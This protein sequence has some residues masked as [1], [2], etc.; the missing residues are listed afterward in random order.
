MSITIRQENLYGAEDWKLVYTSFKNAEFQSY[1]FDTLRQAMIAY[2]QLNYPEEYNDYIQSSEFVALVD[3]VAFV[4]QNLSFRMDLNARENIL[5]T[6]EKRESVLR[7]ARM[8]SY[9]P[10][11]VR[12]AEGFLQVVSLKTTDQLIDSIGNNISNQNLTWGSDPSDLEYER[13][14]LAM[15]AALAS[16][17]QFGSPSQKTVNGIT[18]ESY[19]IYQ[20]DNINVSDSYPVSATTDGLNLNFDILPVILTTAGQLNQSIPNGSTPFSLLYRNDGKGIGSIRTGFFALVKQGTLQNQL[21]RFDEPRANA[22]ID[23]TNS[24]NISEDDFVVQTLDNNGN[25]IKTW[26]RVQSHDYENITVNEFG[27]ANKDLYEVIYSDVDVTSIKFGDGIFANA[28]SGIIRVWYRLAENNFIKVKSNEISNK[29]VNINYVNGKGEA[30]TLTLTLSLQE[31]LTTGIPAETTD[32]IKVNAPEAFYSKN[33]MVTGDDYSGLLPSLNNDVL[34]LKTENRTFSGHSR[35]V[36]LQDPSGKSRPLVEIG[37]DGYFY[38]DELIENTYVADIAGVRTNKFLEDYIQRRL[39]DINFLNFYYGKSDIDNTGSG[40]LFSLLDTASENIEWSLAYADK[41]SSNGF[42]TLTSGTGAPLRVGLTT[43]GS[44]RSFRP[45]SLVKFSNGTTSYWTS[46]ADI[47]G[48]GLGS[49]LA[50]GNYSG[51]LKSGHGVVELNYPVA[52]GD[53]L[54]AILPPMPSAFDEATTLALTEFIDNKTPFALILNHTV[55]SWSIIDTTIYDINT[56]DLWT[57]SDPERQWIINVERTT[58]GWNINNRAINYVF[59]S[60]DLI[61][62]YNINFSAT[63]SI[64]QRNA[65]KDDIAIIASEGNKLATQATYRITGYYN[66]SDGYTDNS[67]VKVTPLDLDNDILPDTPDHFVNL[68][69]TEKIGLAEYVEGDFTYYVPV[70]ST[71]PS[72][73]K[74][75]PGVKDLM[76]KWLHKTPVTQTLNPSLTN[77]IDV[78]VLTKTYYDEFV[79][80]KNKGAKGSQ[81]LT[82]T[83]EQL[84]R[85]FKGLL[86]YKMSTDEVVF[87]PVKFKPLFGTSADSELQAQFKVVK[88]LKSSKTENEIKSK[89]LAAIDKFFTPGNFDFGE[90]FY[91]TELAAYIHSALAEDINSVV[92]VPVSSSGSF[93]SLFQI[94]PN[95]D[96]LVTSVATV[97]DIVVIKEITNQN[98]RKI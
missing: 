43:A 25:V 17:N 18:G 6:A 10:K 75:V 96:E 67:K 11:R 78:Y 65:S 30:H 60:E 87:H 38:Q 21:F 88:N 72:A 68:V 5:D 70:D 37:D 52:A 7:I 13:F 59:G 15:N 61:R 84:R 42:L 29:T 19:G 12:P 44:L 26:S 4:G 69:G 98:I 39:L 45:G 82:D 24:S 32:E 91:F 64:N 33:R 85:N 28:P 16:T 80:W 50:N 53:K 48:D 27:A 71:D 63:S 8:L 36:D 46:V 79:L 77:I 93:G 74:V 14:I 31:N 86:S 89:V 22:V 1:D 90:T 55:P 47:K 40:D 66:Y 54:V 83:S 57:T 95:N 3:L 81:P 73:I 56:T 62:F 23:I 76:F 2:L 35:F 9:K 58:N 34:I 94:K 20:F 41:I 97:N 51:L 49:E 92:I